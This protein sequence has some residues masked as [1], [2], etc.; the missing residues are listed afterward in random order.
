MT[1]PEIVAEAIKALTINVP[2]YR[3]E[4]KGNTVTFWLYGRTVPVK[5]TKPKTRTTTQRRRRAKK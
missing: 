3:Y 4:I 1:H 2:I 5:W